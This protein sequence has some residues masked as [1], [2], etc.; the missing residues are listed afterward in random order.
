MLIYK[1]LSP[2]WVAETLIKRQDAYDADHEFDYQRPIV[3]Q[4]ID[5]LLDT[6]GIALSQNL[7]FFP[8]KKQF[9]AFFNCT[10]HDCSVMA[11]AL[12][13]AEDDMEKATIA[14]LDCRKR[15]N[16]LF[17]KHLFHICDLIL[18]KP[19][20]FVRHTHPI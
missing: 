13:Q 3:H 20:S 4:I 12:N 10:Y 14:Y 6:W 9:N 16:S 7:L 15:T 1:L 2:T 11:E 8:V 19:S 5:R 17:G 18:H